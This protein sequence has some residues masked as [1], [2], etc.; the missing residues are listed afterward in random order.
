[1]TL[2]D[3][4]TCERHVAAYRR[5]GFLHADAHRELD[6]LA[7]PLA[8]VGVE[9]SSRKRSFNAVALSEGLVAAKL[10]LANSN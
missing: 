6:S 10:V 7:Q 9:T 2:A 1:M 3:L 8:S 5:Q 4:I